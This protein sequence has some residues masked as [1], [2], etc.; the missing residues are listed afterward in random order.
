VYV[1][2]GSQFGDSIGR[3]RFLFEAFI[4]RFGDRRVGIDGHGGRENKLFDLTFLTCP[5]HIQCAHEVGLGVLIAFIDRG[6]DGDTGRLVEDDVALLGERPGKLELIDITLCEVRPVGNVFPFTHR[7]VVEDGNLN[8]LGQE[9]LRDMRADKTR[10]AGY[11]CMLITHVY[12][13]QF[14]LFLILQ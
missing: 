5:K 4:H 6:P 8:I 7:E 10:P 13:L 11:Q 2:L 9:H 14:L 1:L 12:P 3:Q